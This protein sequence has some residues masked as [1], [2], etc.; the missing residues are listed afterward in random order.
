MIKLIYIMFLMEIKLPDYNTW[1]ILTIKEITATLQQLDWILAGGYAL[2]LFVR[3]NYRKH[4]D[5]D[6]LI[7]REDQK[8]IL[9]YFDQDRIFIAK[10]GRFYE[11]SDKEYYKKPLQDIWVLSEDKKSWCLQIML[12]DVIDACW[13]YKRN[14]EIRLPLKEIYFKSQEIKVLKPEI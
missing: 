2:A 12:F 6:I 9:K 7:K 1:N 4:N 8:E 11:F 10:E 14:E 5:I 13:I 3:E